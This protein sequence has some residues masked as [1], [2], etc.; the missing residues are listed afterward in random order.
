MKKDYYES[1]GVSKDA[2][3]AEI[4][5]AFRKLA[6]MYHPDNKETG[7]EAKFKEIGEAYAVLS[8]PQKRKQYDQ[9]GSAAFEQGGQGG[10]GG[11]QGGFDAGDINLD[12]I[13]KDLFGGGFQGGF[14][15][16]F[17]QGFT[18]SSRRSS[19]RGSDVK[20]NMPLTFMEAAFGCEKEI[21]LTVND[22]CDKCDGKGGFEE[23][24]C[25]KC[26]GR[27]RVIEEQA[28]IFG[29]IQTQHT[30]PKCHGKGKSY[31]RV[32]DKCDGT[33]IVKRNK[34]ITVTIPEGIDNN[35][36]L[37]LQGKGE[38]GLEGGPSGDLYLEIEVKDHPIFRRDGKDVYFDL[39][40]TITE[41]ILGCKKEIPTLT[42]RGY[43]DIKSGTQNDTKYKLKGKGI[44]IPHSILRG[45]MY[46][47]C[48]VII[49][50]KLDRTQKQLINSLEDTT[51]DD[52][53]QFKRY[54][55]YLKNGK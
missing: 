2:T 25:S 31:K 30:C 15:D 22:T 13:L 52:E 11:F 14:G 10:F 34:T 16:A 48:K 19:R 9:F 40:L 46:A 8:D 23:E 45:D 17:S 1:L 32:C 3:D 43:L 12:D 4:K 49:P 26:G 33:G 37:R 42:G 55:E 29:V 35:M 38:A 6:K 28:S 7:N 24:I 53:T 41:A 21:N 51:L 27:G 39:P 50:T 20:V 36:E 44:K 54:N 5:S 18:G 47:V